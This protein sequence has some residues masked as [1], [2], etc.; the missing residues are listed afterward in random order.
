VKKLFIIAGEASGDLHGANLVKSLKK[1]D[2]ALKIQGWGGERMQAEGTEILKHYREL[3][4]MGFAEVIANLNTIRKNFELCKKQISAFKPDAV[5]LI[6]YPGFNLRMAKWIKEQGIKVIY[7]ISPQVWAWKKSRVK[8]IKKYVDKM[9][10]ILPFEKEFYK[11]Y[12]YPVEFVGHPLLDETEAMQSAFDNEAFLKENNLPLDKKIIALL[13]GSRTQEVSKMLPIMLEVADKFSA[14]HFVI[15]QAPSLSDDYLL[16]YTQNHPNVS[17]IKNKTYPLLNEAYAAL[18]TSG[19]ATLET[20]LFNVPQVVCYKGNYISYLIAKNLVDIQ[21]IS[22]VNLIL[23]KELVKELIQNEMNV[24]SVT[25]ELQK[26]LQ[27][28]SQEKMLTGYREL[29]KK[30]G[31]KG[32]SERAAK[33]ILN[34]IN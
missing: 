23:D 4:F 10:V 13:P 32:A 5:V 7:Y 3:A 16:S 21:Y 12:D 2:N 30:L 8:T 33:I 26:I 25:E 31:E 14:Y 17:I 19:T 34:E 29:V 9:M 18:V 11:K 20:A 1:Q 6:D 15:A 27:P 28:E 22:L 24:K